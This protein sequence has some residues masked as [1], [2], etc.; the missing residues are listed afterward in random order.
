LAGVMRKDGSPN[1]LLAPVLIQTL[2]DDQLRAIIAHEISHITAHD[3]RSWRRYVAIAVFA[4]EAIAFVVAI[5]TLGAESIP[6]AW[7]CILP[8]LYAGMLIVGFL[9]RPLEV[10]ADAAGVLLDGNISAMTRGLELTYQLAERGR[11][12]IFGR[13]PWSWLFFPRNIRPTTHPS[14]K[15]R[16]SLIAL[17]SPGEH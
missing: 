13:E 14:L 1:L 12:R 7:G 2:S 3:S 4:A 5:V 8:A 10:R 6:V 15:A 11:R 9:W 16:L 17:E